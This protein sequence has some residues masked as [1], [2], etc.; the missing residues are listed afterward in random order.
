MASVTGLT[1]EEVR[2]IEKASVIGARIQDGNLIL[3]KPGGVEIPVGT[4]GSGGSGGQAMARVIVTSPGMARP[5]AT[6]VIWIGGTTRPTNMIPG[7]IW[8]SEGT[9]IPVAPTILTTSLTTLAVGAAFYQ[10]LSVSGDQPM[11]FAVTSG[12][13]PAGISLNSSTGVISGSPTT[14]GAYT[15]TITATNAAGS[16]P[17]AFSGSVASA[18]VA[19]NITTTTIGAMTQNVAYSQALAVTGSTP[20]TWGISAGALPA[21]LGINSSTGVISGTPTVSGAF[22]FTVQASNAFGNATRAYSG[23]I[24]SNIVAPNITTTSLGTLTQGTTFSLTLN[25]TGSTPMTFAVTSGSLPAGLTL[26]TSTGSITGTPSAAG[27]YNFTVTATNSAGSDPQAFTGNVGSPAVSP[28]VITTTALNAATVNSPFSQ[29]I[30]ATGGGTITWQVLTGALPAGLNLNTSTGVISGTPTTSGAY[31]FVL[32]ATNSGGMDD[33]SFSGSVN[34]A[35]APISVHGSSAP[36]SSLSSLSD[37]SVGSWTTHQYYVPNAWASLASAKIVGARL[38]LQEG[39]AHI[40]QSWRAALIRREG[41]ILLGNNANEFGG[42][43]QYNNNGSLTEGSALVAGWNELLF[44]TEWAGLPS[45]GSW[46]MGVQIGNGTRYQF[47]PTGS[48]STSFIASQGGNHFVLA[49]DSTGS[50]AA[51]RKFYND[52]RSDFGNGYAID[53]LVRL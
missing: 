12:T 8:F 19:P 36:A 7:D 25:V 34:A 20:M 5:A 22:N 52:S 18:G 10:T 48:M 28:P 33:Q 4:V 38:Y 9:P 51:V 23:T 3:I 46:C 43:N 1:A 21:G 39:S 2:A 13:L 17:Q 16:D 26:N 29:T 15:F 41:G 40:G 37:A 44:T 30:A 45:G 47:A 27:A 42:V 31:T 49:E 24:S 14:A 6:F 35:A 53:V 50:T 32:R 11:T